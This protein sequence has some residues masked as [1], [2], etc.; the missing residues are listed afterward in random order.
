M[1]VTHFEQLTHLEALS[2]G[3]VANHHLQTKTNA[4]GRIEFDFLFCQGKLEQKLY[5]IAAAELC[6]EC[7]S[8]LVRF[9]GVY[10]FLP[11]SR[12][13]LSVCQSLRHICWCVAAYMC[14]LAERRP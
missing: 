3:R 11:A 9:L 14:R 10:L 5:G 2:D 12:L 4:A 6:G 7:E 8:W 1:Q 13:V